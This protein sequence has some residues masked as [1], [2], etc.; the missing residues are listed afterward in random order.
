MS[1]TIQSAMFRGMARVIV[2]W[3]MVAASAGCGVEVGPAY[4]VGVYG[5]YPSDAFIATT[6]PFYYEGRATYWYGGSWYYRNGG[7]WGHY[8]SEPA[9]LHQQRM[10]GVPRRRTYE[11]PGGR[12]GGERSGGRSGGGRR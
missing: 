8:G 6:S 10:Q 3:A 9:A 7:G 5:A 11:S 2:V 4:P 1:R 12:G